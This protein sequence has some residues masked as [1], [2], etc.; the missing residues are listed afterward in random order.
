[1]SARKFYYGD[2]VVFTGKR[3][4]RHQGHRGIITKTTV[5]DTKVRNRWPRIVYSVHCECGPIIHPEAQYLELHES[6]DK[7][8]S[9]PRSKGVLQMRKMALGISTIRLANFLDQFPPQENMNETLREALTLREQLEK[10]TSELNA[11]ERYILDRKYGLDGK[12]SE[13]NFKIG[14]ALN[15]SRESVRKLAITIMQK[16]QEKK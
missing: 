10:L 11:K 8:M 6:N 16:L 7:L 13:T 14:Q 15:I 9:Y 3:Y 5:I 1:M 12:P 4:S 2:L